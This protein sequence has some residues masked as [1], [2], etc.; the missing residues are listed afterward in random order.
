MSTP[1]TTTPV[2]PAAPTAR[3]IARD[4]RITATKARRVVDLVRGRSVTEADAI[5]RFAPQAAAYDVRKVLMSAAANA[6][7]KFGASADELL[8]RAAFVDEGSTWKRMRPRSRS[9]A[10]RILKRTSH[11]TIIVGTPDEAGAAGSKGKTGRG[12][13]IRSTGKGNR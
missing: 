11:I 7:N 12:R 6:E 4:V 13:A 2:V 1:T 10:F 8:V 9:Q 3:A 5:L